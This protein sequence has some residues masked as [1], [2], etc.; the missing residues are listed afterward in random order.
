MRRMMCIPL[1]SE[2]NSVSLLFTIKADTRQRVSA[3]IVKRGRTLRLIK[4]IFNVFLSYQ[5]KRNQHFLFIGLS[6]NNS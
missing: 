5:F 2:C 4:V 6:F 3:F 1:D